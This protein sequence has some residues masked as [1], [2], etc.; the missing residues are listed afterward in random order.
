MKKFLFILT[1]CLFSLSIFS[2]EITKKFADNSKNLKGLYSEFTQERNMTLLEEK[3]ESKGFLVFTENSSMRWQITAPVKSLMIFD[4]KVLSKFVFENGAW[5][6][7]NIEGQFPIEKVLDQV[8]KMLMGDLDEKDGIYIVTE[9]G[10]TIVL[11]PKSSTTK[12]MISEIVITPN[13]DCTEVS[14]VDIK[15]PN[16]DNTLI[17]FTKTIKNPSNLQDAFDLNSLDGYL[18]K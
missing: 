14:S 3:V 17:S 13:A 2:G 8:R 12:K 5:K 7:L 16:G 4:K 11:T 10:K 6:K 15:N 9:T 18:P 1:L